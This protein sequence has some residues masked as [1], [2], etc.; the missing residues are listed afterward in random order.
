[1]ATT[2][3]ASNGGSPELT[4]PPSEQ[5]VADGTIAVSGASYTDSFAQGNP[6]ALYL[7]ISDESGALY[8]YYPGTG[9]A[10]SDS[11]TGNGSD[12][13]TF[14]GSYADVQDII[15]SLTYVAVGSGGSD[16]IDYTIW[17]QAG[18]ETTGEVPVT[19]ENTGTSSDSPSLSEPTSE[20]IAAGATQAVSGSY[21]DSFAAANPGA[22]FLSISD[23]SGTLRATNASGVAVAGSGTNSI[24][25]DTDY[26]D[27]NAVLAS[28]SYTAS[29]GAGTDNI[30]FDIWNQDGVQTTDTVPV[31]ITSGGGVTGSGG[32]TETWTGAVS[33]NWNTAANWSGDV[34]P[35][36]GDTAMIVG[37]TPNNPTLSNAILSGET[38]TLQG[39]GNGAPTVDFDNVTLD[40]VLQ[41]GNAG[42][43]Q[44]GGTLTIGTQGTLETDGNAT[45][46]LN[47][48]AETIVNDG[49]VRGGT[50]GT[51]LIYNGPSAGTAVASFVNN[52]SIATDGGDIAVVSTSS[53][54]GGPPDWTMV[55]DGSI[56]IVNGGEVGLDGTL[57]GGVV[58][59]DGGGALLLERGMALA[60]G[61]SVSGFGQG[62]SIVLQSPAAG[63]GGQL[64]FANGTLEVSENGALVQAIPVSGGYTLGN[65][66]DQYVSGSGNASTIAF[67]AGGAPS[68]IVS[69]DIVAPASAT[70]VQGAT[71][72]LNDV[73][74]ENLGTS[75]SVTIDAG[76]GTLYMNGASG[77]GTHQLTL[78]ATSQYN[79][80]LAS[81][82]Y[83]PAAGTTADTVSITAEPPAPVS[84]TRSIP[85]SITG[86]VSGTGGGPSLNE[87][88][89]ESVAQGGTIAVSG[90]YADSFAAG[91]P[92][93]LFLGISDSD[94]T[95][96]ATNAAGQ[97]V[98]GSGT[99][100]IALQTDYVDVNAI[101][102][103]LHYTAGASSGSDTIQFQ[104]WNQDGVETTASTAVTIDPPALNDAA[105]STTADFAIAGAGASAA[106]LPDTSAGVTG[107]LALNDAVT[108]TVV[109][110]LTASE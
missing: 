43:V 79:A 72:A 96:S 68:G 74:I 42:Q 51:L 9:G 17:N 57:Q 106:T 46:T 12:T 49:L 15:N 37:G 92:G 44:I 18:T 36:S 108:H 93:A 27:L 4:L 94:G 75:G 6:G 66:E 87:P 85:I 76:S 38:I 55:N 80:D 13:L 52:G 25:L 16:T 24:T 84:T 81:L 62:D 105:G 77:S 41:S 88:T 82:T 78:A 53:L 1:V 2:T 20:T 101:L 19:V 83:V 99:D 110:P 47:G 8:G 39:S 60:D 61:A 67:A 11:A 104:V 54:P 109:M 34:V 7:S 98:A 89:S 56:A 73:S 100:S 64:G 50:G 23:T 71:L 22:L 97:A 21:S 103:S 65:F 14:R 32:A 35:T 91:N 86:S 70:V 40:S 5:V 29:P 26:A 63:Q 3:N 30:S 69:P 31:R 59:F 33:S 95:L 48:T 102:G 10:L 90:S 107:S 28:L 45:L 58:A